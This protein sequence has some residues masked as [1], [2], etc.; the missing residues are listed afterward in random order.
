MPVAIFFFV[1]LGAL[2]PIQSVSQN[3]QLPRVD[4]P[5]ATRFM[6]INHESDVDYF[7]F[8]VPSRFSSACHSLEFNDV[9]CYLG[10]RQTSWLT[11]VHVASACERE[12]P[13]TYVQHWLNF[14]AG[15]C[16]EQR[17]NNR[18]AYCQGCVL[19][20]LA[21]YWYGEHVD[22]SIL[23]DVRSKLCPY[24]SWY[25]PY[26]LYDYNRPEELLEMGF[27][28][29]VRD[30]GVI[31]ATGI[32]CDDAALSARACS[33]FCNN[34]KWYAEHSGT[35]FLAVYYTNLSRV[36]GCGDEYL[37]VVWQG[38]GRPQDFNAFLIGGINA[39]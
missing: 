36:C 30:I 28:P 19:G 7:F 31:Y 38:C 18:P 34:A 13:H 11:C 22:G 5:S 2:F 27:R 37:D 3:V 8:L 14:L 15:V 23:P 26:V 24:A 10:G 29:N 17:D 33:A 35:C 9:R 39:T 21:L 16:K 6:E 20:P 32:V 12:L 1:L 25:L 4:I